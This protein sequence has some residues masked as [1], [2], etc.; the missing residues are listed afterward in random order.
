MASACENEQHWPPK[1]CLNAIPARTIVAHVEP[2]QR[3]AYDERA[4]EWD[5]PV[6][7]RIY[8]SE[9]ACNLFIP[10]PSRDA[11]VARCA[12]SHL[13]CVMCRNAGHGGADCPRDR[14]LAR[15][16]ELAEEEGWKRCHGCRAYVEH[17][18]AC[19]HMTCR[20]GA[21]FC[22]V[23]G[24]PWRTC[25]CTMEQL[26][27]AKAEAAARRRERLDRE[28]REEAAAAEA[29]RLV[30]EFEREEAL[31]AELLQRE[32]ERVAEERR[33]RELE[34]RILREGERRRA[35]MAK[36][37]ALRDVFRVLHEM[38]DGLLR[39]KYEESDRL[40]REDAEAGLRRMAD[41]HELE[42][43]VQSA[44]ADSRITKREAKVRAEYIAR[45]AEERR[46]EDGYA[47]KL[48]AYWEAKK[49]GAEKMRVAL[50]DFRM[51]MDA[52]RKVWK[53]WTDNELEAYCH[54]VR[55][56]QAI[57]AEIM[58]MKESQFRDLT[59]RFLLEL[60]EQNVAD[61]RWLQEV[62]AE[63]DR[64]LDDLELVEIEDGEDID[65]WFAKGELDETLSTGPWRETNPS[66]GEASETSD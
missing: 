64:L 8:C 56:Q 43:E 17:R 38:Q 66:I 2:R 50:D 30:A 22:Y 37:E 5:V 13:T 55:E 3:R 45:V 52:G 10:A 63:R 16:N 32:Q 26:G 49:G 11:A 23:C 36:L 41:V 35:V 7:D 40:A 1:C 15:T 31:K 27:R 4:R 48:R 54:Y 25:A 58:D 12:R 39:E 18:D 59:R 65:T 9:A 46:L 53:Q 51:R 44:K 14:D 33:A 57:D 47:A 29:I 20:C 34:A 24:A 6:A 42:R 19:Q 21:E 60:A 28:A 61:R 62:I